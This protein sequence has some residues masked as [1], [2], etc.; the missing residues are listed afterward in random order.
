[1]PTIVGGAL[2]AV[3]MSPDVEAAA[4]AGG[5]GGRAFIRLDARGRTGGTQ[6][7]AARQAIRQI[8]DG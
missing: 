5:C 1:M 3:A 7:E 8:V 4:A 6:T 2:A